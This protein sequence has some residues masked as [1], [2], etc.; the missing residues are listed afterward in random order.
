MIR[1][2]HLEPIHLIAALSV[3]ALVVWSLP[4]QDAGGSRGEALQW[5]KQARGAV[6][7]GDT[8]KARKLVAEAKSWGERQKDKLVTAWA[9]Q[10]AGEMAFADKDRDKAVTAFTSALDAFTELKNEPG[11]AA[12]RLNL[13]RLLFAKGEPADALKHQQEALTH[14]EKSSRSAEAAAAQNDLA[15]SLKALGRVDEAKAAWGKA[16]AAIRAATPKQP[17]VELRILG[18]LAACFEATGAADQARQHLTAAVALAADL[19]DA[20]EEARL[21]NALGTLSHKQGNLD[22]AGKQY[23]TALKLFGETKNT[24]AAEAA[25]RNNLGALLQDQGKPQAALEELTKALKTQT[26]LGDSPGQAR[27]LYNVALVHEGQGQ[28]AKAIDAYEQALALRRKSKDAPGTVKILDNLALLY[29]SQGKADKAKEC[30]D[31]AERLRQ[32]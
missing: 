10:M 6:Q 3:A 21:H 31:E 7:A 19:K 4:A 24:E 2:Y 20:T 8:T 23:E 14:F 25:T 11:M 27:T 30:R 1:K 13:G 12:C 18:E 28:E 32:R 26:Q 15:S 5:L 9:D 17:A 22:E 16:L 29:A